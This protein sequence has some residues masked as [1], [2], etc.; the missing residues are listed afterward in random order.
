MK[1]YSGKS[2]IKRWQADINFSLC[3]RLA[4]DHICES[5]GGEAGDCAHIMG[6]RHFGSRWS[7]V[8]AIALCR[9]C[10]NKYTDEPSD[11]SDFI[12]GKFPG[13]RNKAKYKSQGYQKNNKET[14]LLVSGHYIK[15]LRRMEKTGA[16][17]LKSW[18]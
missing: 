11:W 3:I 15:E 1:R 5:C 12:D 2:G 14:R 17:D 9:K 13:R 6:R 8:N 10:H 7:V 18:N 16:R 4:A